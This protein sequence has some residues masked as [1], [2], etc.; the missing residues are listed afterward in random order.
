M[1]LLLTSCNGRKGQFKI[2]GKFLNLNQG[3]FY[4]Y[5]PDGIIEGI[6]TIKV[7]A[8]RFAYEIPCERQGTLMLVFPNFSQQP[9][10]A[11]SGKSVDI[12][13]NAS[14]LKEM[15]VKGTDDNELM[16]NF[17]KQIANASPV[18]AQKQ[19]EAF[20]KEHPESYVCTFLLRNYFI[21]TDRPDCKK[22]SLLAKTI[23]KQQ[24]KNGYLLRIKQSLAGITAAAAGNTLPAFSDKDI[25]GNPVSSASI[26]NAPVAII[27]V[28][29][30][31]SYDSQDIQRTIKRYVKESG[32]KLKVISICVDASTYECKNTLKRDSITWPNICDGNM[33]DGKTISKLGITNVPY[34]IVMQHGKITATGLKS[35]AL[36]DKLDALLKP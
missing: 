29:S 2:E 27:N 31:W 25:N 7:E 6:D 9:I 23:E 4:V 21:D 5:S 1:I 10:F 20:I 18:D 19:A 16:S 36:R 34:N 11:E 13:G 3:E 28:W 33:F 22:A 35:N 8:G 17:R 14:H 32:G 15:E 24:P 30:T 12:N 26:S